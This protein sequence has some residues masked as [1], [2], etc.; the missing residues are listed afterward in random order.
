MISSADL[1]LELPPT[2]VSSLISF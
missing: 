1:N 2:T